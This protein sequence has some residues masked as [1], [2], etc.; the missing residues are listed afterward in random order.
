MKL[1]KKE[2]VGLIQECIDNFNEEAEKDDRAKYLELNKGRAGKNM[3]KFSDG[4]E[5]E[6]RYIL[7]DDAG[8]FIEFKPGGDAWIFQL[9]PFKSDKVDSFLITKEELKTLKSLL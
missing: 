1:T 5:I 4:T 6:N 7:S 2:L 8:S 9:D 3:I